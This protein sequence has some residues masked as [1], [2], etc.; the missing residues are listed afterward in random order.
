MSKLKILTY[1]DPV[2][3]KHAKA[4]E[5]VEKETRKFAED[6][7]ETM[8][9]APG[10]G[11]AANQVGVLSRVLVL[12]VDWEEVELEEGL[13]APEGAEV[14]AGKLMVGRKPIVLINPRIIHREGTILFKEGCLSCPELSL[15]IERSDK[16]KVEYQDMDGLTK[17]LSGEG[18]LAVAIQHEIDHLD[19]T[20]MIDRISTAKKA[21]AKRK[22]MKLKE[23]EG[24]EG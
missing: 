22:L 13:V 20:L 24:E 10:V 21:L 18:L 9:G 6:M 7:L 17:T 19:G 16:V 2:L 14:V 15:E 4:V 23:E 11:L 5:R 1:P 3:A 8:Y 12:D